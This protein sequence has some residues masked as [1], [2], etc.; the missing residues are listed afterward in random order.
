MNRPLFNLTFILIGENSNLLKSLCGAFLLQ[1]SG[2]AGSVGMPKRGMAEKSN[3]IDF[4]FL[5]S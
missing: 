4:F 3:D 2:G 1:E 5:S